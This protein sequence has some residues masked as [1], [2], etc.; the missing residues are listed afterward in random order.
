[1]DKTDAQGNVKGDSLGVLE[2]RLSEIVGARGCT[3]LRP[4]KNAS[5]KARKSALS[6]TCRAFD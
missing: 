6:Q 3:I 1:M 5:S 2:C 4:L